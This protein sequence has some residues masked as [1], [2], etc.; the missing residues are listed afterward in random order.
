MASP[1][2]VLS[3]ASS[4]KEALKIA[5]VLLTKRLAACV[6]IVPSVTSLYWWKG[7]KEKASEVLLLIKTKKSVFKKMELALRK[8]HSYTIP[9]M[10]A[11]PMTAGSKPYL[12]WMLKE[13]DTR[14]SAVL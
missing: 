13:I 14:L 7:R 2:L 8:S 1:I 4:R 9:E 6:N 5:D 3:T 12:K 11:L 10:I